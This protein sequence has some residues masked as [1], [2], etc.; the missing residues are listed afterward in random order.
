MRKTETE[1]DWEFAT[2]RSGLPSPSRSPMATDRGFA[3]VVKSTLAEKLFASMVPLVEVLRKTETEFATETL[4]ATARSALPS[5]S[6]SPMATDRGLVPV[7]KS[8]LAEKLPETM[9]PLV[10][11]L[12]KTET[13]FP[14]VPLS[15]FATARSGLPSPSRSPMATEA[16]VVPVVKST[17]AAKLFASMVPLVEVLRK[18][19]T[20]FA[21]ETLFATARSALP[22]PSRS[23]MATDMGPAPVPVVK[24]TLA[25]KLPEVML[26]LVEVLRKTETVLDELFATA[27]SALPSPS[28]SPM[29]TEEGVVPVVKSTLAAKLFASM[30]PLVEVLRKTETVLDDEFATARSGLPS[31]SRSPMATDCGA[32]PVVKSTLAAK[33][34]EAMLPL[35]EVLRKTE[36]VFEAQ[37]ATARS[38][39]PSPSRSPMATEKGNVPGVK[40]TFVA[41]SLAAMVDLAGSYTGLKLLRLAH[42]KFEAVFSRVM[43]A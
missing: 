18:T 17:L 34:L 15:E 22:S 29:A 24:S 38:A 8:T 37:F 27:R 30:V 23:P 36:K 9:L 10:E 41:K 7:V 21:T 25:E 32:V 13:E 39:L 5:P 1:F 26:P 16:G 11:V 14:P 33:L 19:E 42:A 3:P 4:F 6:R 35:A 31:P 40:S 28:R 12:R 2:A 20:E 43:G